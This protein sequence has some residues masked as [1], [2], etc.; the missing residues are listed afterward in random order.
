MTPEEKKKWEDGRAM[1]V[2]TLKKELLYEKR[3]SSIELVTLT[4]FKNKL[5]N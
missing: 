4:N 3:N 2:E 5:Q 1:G